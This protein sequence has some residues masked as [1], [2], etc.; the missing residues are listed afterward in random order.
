MKDKGFQNTVS[1]GC[2]LTKKE[3]TTNNCP[4]DLVNLLADS[5]RLTVRSFCTL[6]FHLSNSVLHWNDSRLALLLE[7]PVRLAAVLLYRSVRLAAVL[8][9]RPAWLAAVLLYR[10]ASLA[11]L[12][13]YWAAW[14]G[15]LSLY[16]LAL[17]LEAEEHGVSKLDQVLHVG[18][19]PAARPFI[20]VVHVRGV[21]QAVPRVPGHNVKLGKKKGKGQR[22]RYQ[23][24]RD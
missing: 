19:E 11:S 22:E 1:R 23:D 7:R 9:Y 15:T 3:D 6:L 24:D 2:H 12:L 21:A 20:A 13:L 14:L 10:P 8:L 17:P 4:T 16:W 5:G 18:E